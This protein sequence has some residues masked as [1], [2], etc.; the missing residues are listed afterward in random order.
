MC[1]ERVQ[2]DAL[3]FLDH[4]PR[5]RQHYSTIGCV[6]NRLEALEQLRVERVPLE[7]LRR[8]EDTVNVQK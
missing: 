3:V 5:R 2:Q 6:D 4:S 7:H 8:V 1:D